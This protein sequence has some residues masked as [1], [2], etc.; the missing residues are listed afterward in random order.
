MN[1]FWLSEG[2]GSHSFSLSFLIKNLFLSKLI[3]VYT[4][5]YF[6]TNIL[7]HF[8]LHSPLIQMCHLD[9]ECLL[10]KACLPNKS[11]VT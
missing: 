1:G 10:T 5:Y 11:S 9:D 8:L 3:V 4:L 2:Y 7:K 6:N